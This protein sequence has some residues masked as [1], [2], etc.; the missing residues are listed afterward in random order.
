LNVP[1]PLLRK[2][3]ISI[4]EAEFVKK[5]EIGSSITVEIAVASAEVEL[6]GVAKLPL[7]VELYLLNVPSPLLRK[8]AYQYPKLNS[9]RMR[10]RLFRHR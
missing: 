6:G 7:S 5:C 9:W 1:S 2:L 3:A 8:L 4:P 10:N